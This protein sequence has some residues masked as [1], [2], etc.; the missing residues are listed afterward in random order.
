MFANKY[1]QNNRFWQLINLI[2]VMIFLYLLFSFVIPM[3]GGWS[4]A[5][6]VSNDLKMDIRQRQELL[7][8]RDQVSNQKH[9][10][11][12][13]YE[14]IY[15]NFH[16]KHTEHTIIELIQKTALKNKVEIASISPSS[17]AKTNDS[18]YLI[19]CSGAFKGIGLF[20]DQL[21]HAENALQIKEATLE[22]KENEYS[23]S[24]T[25]TVLIRNPEDLELQ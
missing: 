5:R 20:I 22:H 23:L 16:E 17:T 21:E 24:A 3:Y 8:S 25:I 11:S 18:R 7:E 12:S 13:K 2:S 9:R 19:S 4:E 1:L 15:G 10:L 6:A 14:D